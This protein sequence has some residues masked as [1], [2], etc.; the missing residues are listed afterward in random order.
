MDKEVKIAAYAFVTGLAV[1]AL[2][3][4]VFFTSETGYSEIAVLGPDKNLSGYQ[5]LLH[6]SEPFKLYGYIENHEGFAVYYDYVVKLG[7]QST[8]VSD[9]TPSDAQIISQNYQVVL[10]DQNYTFEMIL[11]LNKTGLNQ[12]LI[13]ELW[14]FS[15]KEMQFVYSGLWA[16]LWV[17]VT[18]T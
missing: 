13:F 17:N 10:N 6:V 16:E 15:T 3:Q 8:T 7:N 11:T 14:M 12:R 5:S 1:F 9:T 4:P 18:K 2:L